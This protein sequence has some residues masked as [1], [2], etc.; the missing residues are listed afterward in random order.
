VKGWLSISLSSII[1]IY[2][3]ICRRIRGVKAEIFWLLHSLKG[4]EKPLKKSL[5]T[6]MFTGGVT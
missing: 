4:A 5:E 2:V 6:K 1:F 3:P